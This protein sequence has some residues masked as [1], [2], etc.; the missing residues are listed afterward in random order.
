MKMRS[1]M[2]CYLA[3]FTLPNGGKSFS[4]IWAASKE[5]AEAI[6]YDRKMGPCKLASGPRKEFRP[7]R[8]AILPGGWMRADVLHSLCYLS[9]LAARHH[10]LGAQDLVCDESP[11]HEFAHLLGAGPR[12]NHGRVEELLKRGAERLEAMIPGMPPKDIVL[13]M[14]D[15]DE[16]MAITVRGIQ[17]RV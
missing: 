7:T 17:A 11:L 14:P 2:R 3:Q 13:Q 12:F 16:W 10:L 8:L 5:K 15:D 6:A 9:F 4:E 1:K